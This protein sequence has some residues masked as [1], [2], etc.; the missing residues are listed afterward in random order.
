M[1]KKI[2]YAIGALV[3]LS[4]IG[5]TSDKD[6]VATFDG[7]GIS[8]GDFYAW[9]DDRG[10]R[11][12]AMKQLKYEINKEDLFILLSNA[13]AKPETVMIKRRYTPVTSFAM[14][15]SQRL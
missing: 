5:C 1:D 12:D 13:S 3:F 14:L 2:L 7:N 9:A 15:A 8:R 4:N 11:S 6:I 10:Y